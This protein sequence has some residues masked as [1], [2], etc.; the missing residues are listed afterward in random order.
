MLIAQQAET[1]QIIAILL[2]GLLLIVALAVGVLYGIRW[3]GAFARRRELR[4][5]EGMPVFGEPGPGLV[6][7]VFHTYSG[8]LLF[9][10][11]SEWRFWATPEDARKILSR[12]NRHN[13]TW[14]FLA[15]GVLVIPILT[16]GN[17]A[18]QLR[19]IRKQAEEAT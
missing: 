19:R 14:G 1:G 7:V 11:Q 8:L 16:L 12:L 10:I 13:L 9:V 15:Y 3:F 4:A 17:Y 6:A 18:T 5:F 2:V